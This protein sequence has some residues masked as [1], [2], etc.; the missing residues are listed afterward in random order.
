MK[1]GAL[2][3][4]VIFWLEVQR[5][6]SRVILNDVAIRET[7]AT[8]RRFAV[9]GIVLF[10]LLWGAGWMILHTSNGEAQGS[11]HGFWGYAFSVLGAIDAEAK[12]DGAGAVYEMVVRVAGAI[13]I[14]GFITSF[15]C[16]IAERISEM[17]LKGLLVT[18]MWNHVLVVGYRNETDD[19]I[20][21]LLSPESEI[22]DPT[23]WY[24]FKDGK[25]MRDRKLKV[26]L[27]TCG[28]VEKIRDEMSSK[29]SRADSRRISYVFGD[30]DLDISGG[31]LADSDLSRPEA[32]EKRKRSISRMLGLETVR[33]VFILGDEASDTGGD[34]ENLVIAD[35]LS[36]LLVT[37][38][39]R[40]P[41]SW[42]RDFPIPVFVKMD[43]IPSFDL[44]KRLDFKLITPGVERSRKIEDVKTYFKPFSTEEGWA[45]ALWG[46]PFPSRPRLPVCKL[47]FRKLERDDYVH[48]VVGPFNTMAEALIV[49]A[50]R[51]CHYPEGKPTRITLVDDAFD[52]GSTALQKLQARRPM[53][54]SL[55]D[56]VI[57]QLT[58]D[59]ASPQV[60]E[61]IDA[62]ARNVH[63]LL[64]VAICSADSDESAETAI[65]LPESVY[66][67]Y[68]GNRDFPIRAK[69]RPDAPW[70]YFRQ[71]HLYGSDGEPRKPQ[72]RYRRVVPFGMQEDAIRPWYLKSFPAMYL[73]AV[74]DW[75]LD[76]DGEC[77]LDELLE[78]RYCA[79]YDDLRRQVEAFKE[80]YAVQLAE[81]NPAAIDVEARIDLL[82]SIL[83]HDEGLV[84]A[85][86]AYAFRRLL[87][88]DCA[89]L[90][91][92]V[93]V[94]DS[95]MSVLRSIGL[96]VRLAAGTD[97]GTLCGRN[98]RLF[99]SAADAA[100]KSGAFSRSLAETEHNRWMADRA[101]MGFRQIRPGTRE[102]KDNE[103]RYH[104]CMIS[105][106]RLSENEKRK[107]R[108][109]LCHIPLFMALDGLEIVSESENA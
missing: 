81:K 15:L 44:A 14:G 61:M 4:R 66:L 24:P 38:K 88:L 53:I 11:A 12:W 48:V 9:F 93:Y 76:T 55:K 49:E 7:F 18:P 108:A 107:D 34:V 92:N 45:R 86:K 75:P 64:S 36:S 91:A 47:D 43:R 60:R 65:S 98:R 26:L 104:Q 54:F 23:K 51:I 77:K 68:D 16:S 6:N 90:W 97:F 82:T 27:Y 70:I 33:Q 85:F 3:D 83:R 19:L 57:D 106:D 30:M 52:R 10:L 102:V 69:Y 56:V 28:D 17:A 20:R 58:G 79:K 103:F 63:C 80:K 8:L 29:F 13:V 41:V 74:Y 42:Y 59:F 67:A 87:M 89:S 21:M 101:L 95:Y 62:E 22:R 2:L 1:F 46:S 71:D 109:S 99:D 105:F 31:H 100:D 25:W 73:N 94:E 50:V 39:R 37:R 35:V 96:S 84:D 78:S 40:N 5:H 32:I 72:I